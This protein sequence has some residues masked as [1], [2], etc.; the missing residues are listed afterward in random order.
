M[1]TLLQ[2]R[3]LI[4]SLMIFFFAQACKKE[5]TQTSNALNVSAQGN[6]S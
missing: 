4:F 6:A 3:T 2:N 1:K 5:T